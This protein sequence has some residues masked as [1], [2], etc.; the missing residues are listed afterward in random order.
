MLSEGSEFHPRGNQ[1]AGGGLS[2]PLLPALSFL[3]LGK[4]RSTK[5]EKQRLLIRNRLCEGV[6]VVTGLLTEAERQSEW[7]MTGGKGGPRCAL[8]GGC[9]HGEAV[10]RLTSSLASCRPAGAA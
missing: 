6:T 8:G 4:E 7:E 1:G 5:G 10:G 2:G 9:W 3:S